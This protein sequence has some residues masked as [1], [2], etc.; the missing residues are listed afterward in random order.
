MPVKW[1]KLNIVT[2][3]HFFPTLLLC[4]KTK[5]SLQFSQGFGSENKIIEIYNTLKNSILGKSFLKK[6]KSK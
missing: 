3:E 6:F 2:G 4:F 1:K 5:H